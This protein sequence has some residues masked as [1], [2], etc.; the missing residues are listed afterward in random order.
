MR[1]A[2]LSVLYGGIIGNSLFLLSVVAI[3][4]FVPVLDIRSLSLSVSLTG[5]I[6]LSISYIIQK[7]SVPE[8]IHR[9][10]DYLSYYEHILMLKEDKAFS[11]SHEFSVLEQNEEVQ[12]LNVFSD[13][14][15]RLA[16]FETVERYKNVLGDG[17]ALYSLCIIKHNYIDNLHR[18]TRITLTF[19]F[20][21]G[22]AFLYF[23]AGERILRII[24]G[25][26]P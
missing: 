5:A 15:F 6:I 11:P 3:V 26:A 13:N 4:S 12:S 23:P 2:I 25:G 24:I 9:H 19:T 16:R 10:R 7:I 1:W 8:F 22:V 21:L 14:Q 17:A 20:G 18:V